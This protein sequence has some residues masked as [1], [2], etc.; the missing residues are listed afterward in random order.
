MSD[1]F[2][3]YYYGGYECWT[4]PHI[5]VTAFSIIFAALLFAETAIFSLLYNDIRFHSQLPW[6]T[7][8]TKAELLKTLI[9]FLISIALNIEMYDKWALLVC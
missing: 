7:A 2:H 3:H 1:K 5:V 8:S 6:G 9:K 4:I